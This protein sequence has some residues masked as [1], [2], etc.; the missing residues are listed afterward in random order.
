[1]LALNM[2]VLSNL[3]KRYY[4]YLGL[5]SRFINF[6]RFNKYFRYIYKIIYLDF[7]IL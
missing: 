2:I 6:F 5:E 7:I 4:I 1:M 3:K